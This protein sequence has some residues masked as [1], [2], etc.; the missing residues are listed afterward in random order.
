[1]LLVRTTLDLPDPMFRDLKTKAARDGVTMKELV[2]SF[3]ERGLYEKLAE[4]AVVRSPLPP[5]REGG[6]PIPSLTNA[7]MDELFLRE[8]LE[9]AGYDLSAVKGSLYGDTP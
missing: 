8:D 2:K 3:V 9:R 7:E 5:P 4:K 6:S 1:M